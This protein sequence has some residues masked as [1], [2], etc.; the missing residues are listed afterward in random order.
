MSAE[1]DKLLDFN[2][3]LDVALLDQARFPG[4]QVVVAMYTC[5]DEAQRKQ[6]NAFMTTFQEHPQE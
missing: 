5:R 6:I 3:P 2:Q 4:G 1:L